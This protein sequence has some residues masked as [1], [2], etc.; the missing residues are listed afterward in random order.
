MDAGGSEV[1][2]ELHSLPHHFEGFE[3][4]LGGLAEQA[5]LD[6]AEVAVMQVAP[7]VI[8]L[9]DLLGWHDT[10][11]GINSRRKRLLMNSA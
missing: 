7:H 9:Q 8:E 3:I 5:S 6:E 10:S 4:D 1:N 2:A 11:V